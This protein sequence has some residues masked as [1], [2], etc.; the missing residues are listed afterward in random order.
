MNSVATKIYKKI[1]LSVE[2]CLKSLKPHQ[3]VYYRTSSA[4]SRSKVASRSRQRPEWGRDV[5][6]QALLTAVSHLNRSSVSRTAIGLD[7]SRALPIISKDDSWRLM[8]SRSTA[9][10][11]ASTRC[12]AGDMATRSQRRRLHIMIRPTLTNSSR[13]TRGK[14]RTIAYSYKF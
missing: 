10:A 6:M 3:N 11:M 5:C 2:C 4:S 1:N 14:K 9:P 8:S 7:L 12:H 13:S